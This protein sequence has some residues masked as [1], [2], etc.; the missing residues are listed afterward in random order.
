MRSALCWMMAM[1]ALVRPTSVSMDPSRLSPI[2][3]E[4]IWAPASLAL[5]QTA[6]SCMR[7]PHTFTNGRLH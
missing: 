5:T 7:Y 3:Q 4:M 6:T 1:M 2:L